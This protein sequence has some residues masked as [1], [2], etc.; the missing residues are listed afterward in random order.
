MSSVTLGE[1]QAHLPELIGQLQPGEE[2][3]ITEQGQPLAKV[4]KAERTSW[5]CKAGSA[6]GKIRMAAD[7][8]APLEDFEEYMG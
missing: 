6:A 8:D 2:M 7:F 3:I 5:P 1:A 4:K